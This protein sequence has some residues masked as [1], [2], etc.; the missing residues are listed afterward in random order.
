VR[1]RFDGE[2]AGFGTAS[3]HRVVIG[4]WPIS[5]FGSVADVMVE[6]PDGVRTLLAPEP[7]ATFVASTY[8][9]DQVVL[10][11]VE[12]EHEH[13]RLRVAADDLHV[14]VTIGSRAWLGRA[15]RLVPRTV[16]RSTAWASLVDPVARVALS[17]VRTRGR[18]V[19]GRQEWYG[20]WDVHQLL[21]VACA[22]HGRDLGPMAEV[23]PPVRF[24][25]GSTPRRP[26]ITALRTT[27]DVP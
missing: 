3:G 24:G 27:I 10:T 23:A 9:F 21:A 6:A 7:L 8:T 15:L 25:F 1:Y 19:D 5:P 4:R 13:D 12:A 26:S 16:A 14:E 22:W 17:G 2:I 11:S 20:A 18:T